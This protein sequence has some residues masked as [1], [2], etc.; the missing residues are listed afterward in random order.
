MVGVAVVQTGRGKHTHLR[1]RAAARP[2]TP[3]PSTPIRMKGGHQHDG[4]QSQPWISYSENIRVTA[5]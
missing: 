1:R 2:D 3:P 4:Q 5:T